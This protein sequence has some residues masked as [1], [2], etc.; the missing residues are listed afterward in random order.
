MHI[1]RL[2]K[3]VEG[4]RSQSQVIWTMAAEGGGRLEAAALLSHV[5]ALES[6]VLEEDGN[7]G[8][9]SSSF[10]HRKGAELGMCR[11]IDHKTTKEEK[12]ILAMM[13]YT[14]RCI[15]AQA[16][17]DSVDT[18][19]TETPV[20]VLVVSEEDAITSVIILALERPELTV[21]DSLLVADEHPHQ[22]KQFIGSNS[23]KQKP[24][25]LMSGGFVPVTPKPR[26]LIVV[27]TKSSRVIT[28]EFSV[29][30]KELKL[31]RRKYQIG[32][33]P[34]K[35]VLPYFEPFPRD[36]L[37]S[38]QED[39]PQITAS[40]SRLLRTRR[41]EEVGNGSSKENEVVV[42]FEP[43][44]GV[45][46]LVACSI[47]REQS[48]QCSQINDI[49]G[50]KKEKKSTSDEKSDSENETYVWI[51]YGD[52]TGVR[53]HHAGLF[54]SVVQKHTE[55]VHQSINDNTKTPP[56]LEETLGQPLIK[57][58]AH[59][60]VSIASSSGHSN[61][62]VIIPIPRYHPT[63]LA[64]ATNSVTP[65]PTSW[66]DAYQIGMMG[67][68]IQTETSDG[69]SK[70]DNE[71]SEDDDWTKDYEAIVYCKNNFDNAFPTLVF[72]TSEDQYPG[73]FQ[74]DLQEL[75]YGPSVNE[76]KKTD[77]G[78]GSINPISAIVGGIF[79]VFGV[80]GGGNDDGDKSSANESEQDNTESDVNN[81][82]DP[83]LPFPTINRAPIDL[84]A[85]VE[86]H[87]SPRQITQCTIDP[88]GDLAALTDTLG[89]VSLIDLKTKQVIRMW[90]GFRETSC[91][92]IQVPQGG[93]GAKTKHLLYLVIHS[94][95]RCVIEVWQMTHGARVKSMQ[96]GREAQVISCRQ[97]FPGVEGYVNK[98]YIVNSN[99]PH[100]NMNQLEAIVVELEGSENEKQGLFRQLE[101][102]TKQIES[103][104]PSQEASARMNRLQQLLGETNVECQSVDVYKA[105]EDIESLEH[106]AL[107]LDTIATSPALEEKMGVDGS[108]FQRLALSLC[109][110]K[111][112]EAISVAE[113][114]ASTNPHVELLSFKIAFYTQICNGFDIL[115]KYEM[116][117][118]D[119][120]NNKIEVKQPE[121]WGLEA[122]GWTSTYLKI[123]KQPIDQ[124]TISPP[125][126]P[127]MFFEYSSCIVPPKKWKT[128]VFDENNGGYSFLL[129]DSSRTRRDIITR[130]FRPLINDV[131]SFN[132]VNQMFDSL[133]IKKNYEYKLKCFGEWFFGL[134]IKIATKNAVFAKFSPSVRWLKE[135][136]SSQLDAVLEKPEVTTL[137]S[138]FDFIRASEDLVRAFWL[139][140]LCRETLYEVATEYEEKTYGKVE[141]S[142][143]IT[144]WDDLLRQLRVCLLVSLRLYGKPLGACPIS[145]KSID[146]VDN[147]SVFEWL[148]RDELSMSHKQEEIASL[149][150]ACQM[151]SRAFDPSK[152]VGDGKNRW[153]TV[154]RSCLTAAL[155]E[156]ERSE[157][158]VD[159][160]DD[161]RM[162]AL[163]LFLRP[164]NKPRLLVPHRVL[165]LASEWGRD[166]SR[167]DI[168]ENAV[169]AMQA[170][171]LDEHK[172]LTYAVILDVWQSQIRP[173]YRA[174]ML[175]FD[176]VQEISSEVVGPLLI[177][178]LWVEDFSKLATQ[179]LQLLAG[180]NFD[181][182]EKVAEW[183]PQIEGDDTTWPPVRD[184]FI[185]Q[186]LVARNRI[187]DKSALE[188]HQTLVYALRI[189]NDLQ[190]ISESIPSFYNLFLPESLFTEVFYTE[191][192][193]EK[194]HEF[195]QDSIVAFAKSY[196][197]PSMDTLDMGDI[198]TLADLWDFDRINVNTL[199]LLSM[200]EFGKDA[201]VDELLT[202]SSSII[203][204][205]HFVD[206]GLDIMC[207]R[208]NN[209]L[210]VDPSDEIRGIMGTLD[211]DICEWVKAKAE[212]SEPLL[213]AKFDVKIGS[214]HLFGLRLLSLAASADVSKAERIQ[215]HSLIVLSGT[216][217]K[218][219]ES[220]A[221]TPM[222]N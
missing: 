73:R 138:L 172:N 45:T 23:Q 27:G 94:R 77:A 179:I 147:F 108:S 102:E 217:V 78:S 51:G 46:S 89:R 215:I 170:M 122:A 141:A 182:G 209:L 19:A 193:E 202:K 2:N 107:C 171:S 192:I 186:R 173:I 126:N 76:D 75:L 33:G 203:S 197:G 80:G 25:S 174:M 156:S 6:K 153:K 69:E 65:F 162:G 59:L 48:K 161:E 213:N 219:L 92:W 163:H 135:I 191:E 189:N 16:V 21:D 178:S 176:D 151:S 101:N 218:V 152:K 118:D 160:D 132:M 117:R 52:G 185:L 62:M 29:D 85:G 149:E 125:E 123:S 177:D 67:R 22:K 144:R 133:G 7:T 127:M 109:R 157:Y 83:T 113:E 150:I 106:L 58:Q 196:H 129:S 71:N 184:C 110:Q 154:Q 211:A 119:D 54:P 98:C 169:Y 72:Y 11:I 142:K 198:D 60:P 159:F 116:E 9:S 79:G 103:T 180:I 74:G 81:D 91:N 49:N 30:T 194:Q 34:E 41:P 214:T 15:S 104:L 20:E 130:I 190:K 188:T 181:E 68:G 148:A 111:L 1:L 47:S 96:V 187:L 145:V 90:K 66:N 55:Q 136:I 38:R 5:K 18:S 64:A 36:R 210:N 166:P 14:E 121:S 97:K 204:V 99:V 220:A 212:D 131:F 43:T 139:A 137:D 207:R 195:M 146:R 12:P 205:Q 10:G 3:A 199:F 44:G 4:S 31:L 86:M 42:P 167:M 112:N 40:S 124:D 35:I 128:A 165:L 183:T 53:L 120:G 93:G 88:D 28:V 26:V 37:T 56:S 134:P 221:E 84:Y 114:E 13:A 206:E 143:I 17:R 87:D 222:R 50:G 105:M 168:L 24:K 164:H 70:N 200:Y 39:I 8:F 201:A 95:Q 115:H 158:L 140:T 61:R 155:G 100:S 175:G 57:W 63:P 32:K 208:L 216:I 82:W